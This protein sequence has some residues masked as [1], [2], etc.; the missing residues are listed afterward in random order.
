[1]QRRMSGEDV[2]PIER[3]AC[4]SRHGYAFYLAG[5]ENVWGSVT[6]TLERFTHAL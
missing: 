4:S 2:V 5:M 1:M 6:L 3:L